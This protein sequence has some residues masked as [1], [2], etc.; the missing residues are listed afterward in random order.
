MSRM[1]RARPQASTGG[2]RSSAGRASQRRPCSAASSRPTPPCSRPCSRLRGRPLPRPGPGGSGPRGWPRSA[3]SGPRRRCSSTPAPPGSR[4]TPAPGQSTSPTT[5]AAPVADVQRPVGVGETNSTWI[6]SPA[7][8]CDR[9]W[10]GPPCAARARTAA[11][12]D[13]ARVKLTKPG[14]AT[15]A[16]SRWGTGGRWRTIS[17]A[18]AGLPPGRPGGHEGGVGRPVAVAAVAGALHHEGQI[19]QWR[20]GRRRPRR[21]RSAA[22]T[23]WWMASGN[24]VAR[25]RS[26]GSV[27]PTLIQSPGRP[28]SS[29]DRAPASGAGCVGSN[30][31]EGT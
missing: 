22:D 4:R 1:A 6:R 17:A 11:Y 27:S 3:P 8:A 2:G 13:G 20:A 26:P 24:T 7:P 23:A 25:H 14:P 28:R 19:V 16:R 5:A 10:S 15:S 21:Q 30:P 31:A 29:G 9:A 12:H 18:I